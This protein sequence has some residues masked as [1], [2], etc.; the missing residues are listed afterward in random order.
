MTQLGQPTMTPEEE[1]AWVARMTGKRVAVPAP[2]KRR[3]TARKSRPVAP[4][5]PDV[6]TRRERQPEAAL[7]VRNEGVQNRVQSAPPPTGE[8]C[9]PHH[10]MIEPPDGPT[11]GGVCKKCGYRRQFFNSTEAANNH[12]ISP[13]WNNPNEALYPRRRA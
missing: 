2:V 8:N 7:P 1:A 5:R 4:H 13:L 3:P 11:S 10:W 12:D 6:R 9:P